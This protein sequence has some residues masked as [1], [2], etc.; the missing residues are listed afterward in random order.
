MKQFYLFFIITSSLFSQKNTDLFNSASLGESRE[1]TVGLPTSYSKNPDKKYPVLILLDG[2]YLFDPFYGALSYGEYWEDIPET[3]VIG[4]NQNKNNE[5]ENDSDYDQNEGVPTGSGAKFFEFLGGE[6]LPY[7]EKKYRTLPFRIIAGHDLTAGFLNFFLYKEQPLFNAYISLSPDLVPGMENLI[8]AR[9][10]AMKQPIFYYQ[11]TAD[12]DL[13]KTDNKLKE[14]QDNIKNVQNDNLNYKF[15]DFKSASHYSLVLFSIPSAL[16]QIFESYK[17][18]SKSEYDQKIAI[19]KD[20]Q[21]QYLEKKYDFITK[22]LGLKMQVR[23]NDL[24]AIETAILKAKNYNELDKLSQVAS[25]NYP[26]SMQGDYLLALMYE[27]KGDTERAAKY[28]QIAFLKN[29]VGDLTKDFMME[30]VE[31]MKKLSP[32]K[33]SKSSTQTIT[34]PVVETTQM[35]D[36]KTEIVKEDSKIK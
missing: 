15:D 21:V 2:D 29:E 31:A 7:I 13:S 22:S 23:F 34:E 35:P 30:K 27:N 4:I 16:Y 10:Q 28:Y 11:S 32:K 33:G 8:P 18:I 20:D 17:A 25:K 9:L 26:K 14:L 5:R 36:S 1:I 3:I 12:G 19:L 6:L 24:K